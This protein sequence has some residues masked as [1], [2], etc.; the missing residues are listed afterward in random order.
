MKIG[1][2]LKIRLICNDHKA[3]LPHGVNNW[4]YNDVH[5]MNI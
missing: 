3:N 4:S 5:T 2:K 1:K